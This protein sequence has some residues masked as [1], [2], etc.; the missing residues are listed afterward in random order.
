MT[1]HSTKNDKKPGP[2]PL[3]RRYIFGKP[4][5]GECRIGPPN[6]SFNAIVLRVNTHYKNIVEN[7][8]GYLR[9]QRSPANSFPEEAKIQKKQPIKPIDKT[10][11]CDKIENY[12]S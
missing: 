6:P 3:S 11:N 7:T 12:R 5:K 2:Y 9:L 4:R 1:Y 8:L 10:K